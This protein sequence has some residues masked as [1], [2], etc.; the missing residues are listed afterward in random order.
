[1][2]PRPSLKSIFSKFSSRKLSDVKW[3]DSFEDVHPQAHPETPDMRQNPGFEVPK[4][5]FKWNNW[6]YVDKLD[7]IHKWNVGQRAPP[8]KIIII[9]TNLCNLK[10]PYCPNSFARSSGRFRASDELTD[11]QWFNVVNEALELGVKE[12]YVL[13]G[14]EPLLRKKMLMQIYQM[15]KESDQ[16]HITELIT[17]AWFFTPEDIDL[18][19]GKRL[20]NK[21]LFSIDGHNADVHD[22]VRGVPGSWERA[23]N[24][25]KLFHELKQKY[26][27]DKPILHMNHIITV[28]SYQHIS[29]TIELC[30]ELGIVECAIHPMREYEETQGTID[31]LMLTKEQEYEMFRELERA[32]K[33][34]DKYLIYLNVSMVEE[35]VAKDQTNRED[36]LVGK[37]LLEEYSN[38]VKTMDKPPQHFKTFCY[39]PLYSIFIDPKGNANYCCTAGDSSKEQNVAIHG[40]KNIWYGKYLSGVRGTMLAGGKTPKCFNCGLYDMTHDLK[41]DMKKFVDHLVTNG[42]FPKQRPIVQPPTEEVYFYTD[43]CVKPNLIQANVP[44]GEH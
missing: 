38:S 19:A 10:C 25:V 16:E 18:I 20:I 2:T 35:T 26:G 39:E 21:I 33:L 43:N 3:I 17:N 34:A 30:H 44:R 7:R 27:S 23:T 12:F 11:T 31:H 9:P 41:R 24:A 32:Q 4:D 22:Y 8:Y 1:M 28:R 40:F 42:L 29:K 14:G 6:T 15:I 37:E 36:F 13:G 5:L